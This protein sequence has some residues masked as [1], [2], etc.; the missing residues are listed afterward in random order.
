MHLLHLHPSVLVV[1]GRAVNRI[2]VQRTWRASCRGAASGSAW[3]RPRLPWFPDRR[4]GP[5]DGARGGAGSRA[6]GPCDGLCAQLRWRE[7]TR[8]RAARNRKLNTGAD[9]ALARLRPPLGRDPSSRAGRDGVV[10]TLG[11]PA[12]AFTVGATS[13]GS[14]PESPIAPGPR[15]AICRRRE[16][17]GE[18]GARSCGADRIKSVGGIKARLF[19]LFVVELNCTGLQGVKCRQKRKRPFSSSALRL[20]PAPSCV[21]NHYSGV[22]TEEPPPVTHSV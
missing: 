9:A 22:R 11:R 15:R 2:C 18:R 7:D 1:H 20:S 4:V 8:V 5:V 12:T 19:A 13:V 17:I 14:M 10:A 16:K 6:C 3:A 21:P